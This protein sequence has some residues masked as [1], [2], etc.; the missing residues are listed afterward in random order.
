MATYDFYI[1]S[2]AALPFDPGSGTF[3]FDPNYDF[4]ED[5]VHLS[6]TDDD[7][8]MDGDEKADEIGEDAN[9]T[10]IATLPNGTQIASGQVYAEQY[11]VIQAP[12]GTQIT[13]DRIEMDGVLI[14]YS[15]SQPLTPG[16]TYSYVD[17]N[18]VDNS[19]ASQDGADTRLT[20]SQYQAQSVPCFV[21][22]T[23]LLTRDGMTPVDWIGVGDDVWTQDHGWQ[24]VRW[25]DLR[26]FEE[27]PHFP[28]PVEIAAGALGPGSPARAIRVSPQ[29][30][31]V[32]SGPI[33]VLH[34]GVEQVL[35]AA[36]H[37]LHWPGVNEVSM[38]ADHAYQHLL[39]DRHEVLMSEGVA[40]E[41][42]YL[43]EQIEVL[44]PGPPILMRRALA[45]GHRQTAR[46]C[47]SARE[48]RVLPP[49]RFPTVFDVPEDAGVASRATPA[50]RAA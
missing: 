12:D 22:G 48:A 39:F 19:L 5:R 15:P 45:V 40:T 46:L 36:K 34:F 20:Y 23:M 16:M 13:I 32:L 49:G 25:R 35:V 3:T 7:I 43:G 17:G 31:V 28:T 44:R 38:E 21:S 41:S 2:G 10:A 26:H 1:Y 6:V 50:V 27:G 30:R 24:K 42:L 11:A 14:G 8:Y 37:L 18:D 33:C 9:Q 47:L 29:H 4:T